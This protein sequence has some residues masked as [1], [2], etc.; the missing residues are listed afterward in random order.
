MVYVEWAICSAAAGCHPSYGVGNVEPRWG[1]RMY[2]N[3][4]PLAQLTQLDGEVVAKD[5][6]LVAICANRPTEDGVCE[7]ARKDGSCALEGRDVRRC[8]LTPSDRHAMLERLV[9][10]GAPR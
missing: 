3:L 6:D 4:A 7:E 5:T 10:D 8:I 2:P 1:I 9:A